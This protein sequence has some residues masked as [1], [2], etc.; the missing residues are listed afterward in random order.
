MSKLLPK[1][2]KFQLL[3]GSKELLYLH[4]GNELKIFWPRLLALEL[5]WIK[6]GG[7]G[8]GDLGEGE[9]K[10]KGSKGVRVGSGEKG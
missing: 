6:S 2:G 9:G 7:G 8:G 5:G 10:G 1:K 4:E 3:I